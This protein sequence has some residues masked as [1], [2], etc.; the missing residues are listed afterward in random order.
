MHPLVLLFLL[1][2]SFHHGARVKKTS[3]LFNQFKPK[4]PNQQ[5]YLEL[6]N[7][8]DDLIVAVTGPAGSGKTFMACMHAIQ[9]LKDGAIQKIVLTRPAVSVDEDLGF[10]PGNIDKKMLPWT[11]PM[12]DAFS[13]VYSKSELLQLLSGDKIEICPLCF[14][15]GR[16]FDNSFIIADEMQNSTPNQM[17]MLLTRIGRNSKMVVNGDLEQSDRIHHNG[18]KDLVFKLKKRKGEKIH[19]V[20]M[21]EQD[22]QRSELVSYVLEMYQSQ[23]PSS[24]SSGTNTTTTASSGTNTTTTASAGTNTTT[25]A[26]A[27]TNSSTTNTSCTNSTANATNLPYDK[28]NDSALIPLKD[29]YVIDYYRLKKKYI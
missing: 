12:F 8:K 10:L 17:L 26:S 4:S 19:L 14:M 16:T 3:V 27:G 9:Q 18:L 1:Y 13:R 21:D 20:Q 22:I 23:A 25:T 11:K 2:L 5:H 7:R 29:Y 15:R 6:L 28:N 24:A